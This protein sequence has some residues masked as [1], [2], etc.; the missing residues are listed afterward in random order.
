[1]RPDPFH[2]CPLNVFSDKIDGPDEAVE[3]CV[4]RASTVPP[5]V[6]CG[7]A[8]ASFHAIYLFD[9]D[10]ARRWQKWAVPSIIDPVVPSA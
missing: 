8:A 6:L 7:A 4:A 2:P 9:F 3:G 10:E 1:M 5:W